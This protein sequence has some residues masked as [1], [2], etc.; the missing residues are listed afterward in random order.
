MVPESD[1]NKLELYAP[2]T[3]PQAC[4][5]G[6]YSFPSLLGRLCPSRH[7]SLP[8]LVVLV[9]TRVRLQYGDCPQST[10]TLDSIARR[11]PIRQ[12]L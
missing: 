6:A 7:L 11:D 5:Y 9:R 10:L 12:T 4:V 8:K 2:L 1:R 3:Q